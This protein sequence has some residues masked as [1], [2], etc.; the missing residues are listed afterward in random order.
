MWHVAG[1]VDGSAEKPA[2]RLLTTVITDAY[3][4]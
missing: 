4:E 2:L 3:D 1:G